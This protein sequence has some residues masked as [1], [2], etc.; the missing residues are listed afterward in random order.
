MFL[1]VLSL[2]LLSISATHAGTVVLDGSLGPGGALTG[3]N[4]TIGAGLGTTK[5]PNLFHSFSQFDLSAGDVATF[6]GPNTIQNILAR[7]TGG[8]ASSINGTIQ[9]TISGANLF[10]INP[11][12]I[13]FGANASVDV[14]GSFAATTANYLK[15]SDGARFVAALGADDSALS[16]A[17][18]SAFG[19][20]GNN[21]GTISVQQGALLQVPSGKTI[22]LV[23]GDISLD[24][25][26]IQAPGGQ[27]N[28]ASV[29]SAGE[30][31]LDP[32]SLT[33]SAFA[34]AFPQAGQIQMQDGAQLDASGDG[35]GR[36]VIRGGSLTVDNS[37]ILANTTGSGDGQ[38]IDVAI[39]GDLNLL[40]GGQITSIST[41]GL[42]N[43]GNIN[44]NAGSI[45]L[46][47]GGLF[48]D[49]GN[50]TTEIST[51]TG[52]FVNG[53][54]SG[55]G[56]NITIQTG[57]LTIENSAQISAATYDAGNAGN[58]NINASSIQM[59]A[60]LT[61]LAWITASTQ[62]PFDGGGNAGNI[63][64]NTGSLQMFNGAEL[65]A[66]ST[67]AGQAGKIDV[68]A[69]TISLNSG[70][71]IEAAAFG[72]GNGGD[73]QVTATK[74]LQIDGT[75]ADFLTGIQAVTTTTAPGGNIQVN[76]GSLEMDNNGSIFTSSYA[77]V[78]PAGNVQVTTG[79]LTLG[80]GSSI[81]AQG[82]SGGNAGTVS[83]NSAN[84]ILLTGNSA[85][86]T[87]APG[88]SGGDINVTAGSNIRLINSQIAANAGLDGGNITVS[89]P[90]LVYLLNS[91]FNAQADSTDTGFGNGGNLTIDP[92]FLILND[93]SLISKSSFGNGGNISILS[94]FFFQSGAL[95]DASAPFGLP[96]TVSVTAPKIDL[97]GSLVILPENL[98]DAE[99]LLRPDCGV[100]Q[101]DDVSTFVVL[102]RGGLPLAPGGFVPSADPNHAEK[103]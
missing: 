26:L 6:T 103:K 37:Q 41:Q 19:F 1:R 29:Q 5:G 58:I 97:S 64:I 11:H 78:G 51:A 43:G 70:G 15:L 60:E 61:T 79:N 59:D 22:S 7:V 4:Y 25:A 93:S 20:L 99:S 95:I 31:P 102:G 8:G 84:N 45:T 56:G 63:I 68:T 81:F 74:T 62:D 36:I 86:S 38:G 46:N 92:S 27:I 17:P 71:I 67:C 89:A 52:D 101:S 10:L 94:D 48:D 77:D 55:N 16:T 34:S 49:L 12:G 75:A 83:V 18:V 91:S 2:I 42:G 35:G 21:P 30:V 33:A 40:N 9:S 76:A 88:S 90:K 100:R 44:V 85:I 98:L 28:L 47:G 13:I 57:N 82:L 3:P 32:S 66:S 96:G 72:S 73:V 39:S 69:G 50:P 14:S 54:G 65:F 23:G 53:G 87:S 80:H 24:G